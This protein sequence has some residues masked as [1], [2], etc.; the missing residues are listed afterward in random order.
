M[1]PARPWTDEFGNTRIDELFICECSSQSHGIHFSLWT[2]SGSNEPWVSI[3]C[4]A[5]TYGH[6]WDRLKRASLYVLGLSPLSYDESMLRYED[7]PR[8]RLMIDRYE[9]EWQKALEDKNA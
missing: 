8:L 3:G 9:A 6:I 1:L 4:V 5:Q 2:W 7:I